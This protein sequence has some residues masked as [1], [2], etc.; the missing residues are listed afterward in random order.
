MAKI[1]DTAIPALLLG[2]V[3]SDPIEDRLRETIR[4]TVETMFE[5]ELAAFLGRIRYSRGAGAR[6]GYRNGRREVSLRREPRL[7]RLDLG[8]GC[9]CP[10]PRQQVGHF[11]P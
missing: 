11:G 9:R 4:A 1:T 3:G 2:E 7:R 10:V 8:P 6:K 5:E